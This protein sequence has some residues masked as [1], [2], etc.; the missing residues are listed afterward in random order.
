MWAGPAQL[1]GPGLG[2]FGWADIGPTYLFGPGR[3]Q[4]VWPWP[5]LLLAE[6]NNHAN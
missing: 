1:T 5:A 6:P 4:M 3:T 2:V